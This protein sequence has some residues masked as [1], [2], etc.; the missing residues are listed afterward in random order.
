[1]PRAVTRSKRLPTRVTFRV[2]AAFKAFMDS[3]S[4]IWAV[5]GWRDKLAYVAETQRVRVD[6][7]DSTGAAVPGLFIAGEIGA[8]LSQGHS[9][10]A[11]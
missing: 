7:N 10:A 1:M 3:T 5:Q 6:L 4:T 8:R 9:E 11:E 2:S